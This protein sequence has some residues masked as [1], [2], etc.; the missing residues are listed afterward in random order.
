MDFRMIENILVI[1][2]GLDR[3]SG[4]PAAINIAGISLIAAG[5]PLPQETDL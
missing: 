1:N 3:G 5:K 2:G 4:F